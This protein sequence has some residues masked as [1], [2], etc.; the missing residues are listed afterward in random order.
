MMYG[1][2]NV[3]QKKGKFLEVDSMQNNKG[4]AD[5]VAFFKPKSIATRYAITVGSAVSLGASEER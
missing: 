3:T 1:N 5:F 4:N 2:K